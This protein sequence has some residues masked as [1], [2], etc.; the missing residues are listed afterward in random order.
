MIAL[1]KKAASE[2]IADP[3]A[4]LNLIT[5]KF[6]NSKFL[7][8]P[9]GTDCYSSFIAKSI[10][11]YFPS[12]FGFRNISPDF[13]SNY[14]NNAKA[15]SYFTLLEALGTTANSIESIQNFM[16]L[17]N[18]NIHHLKNP[19]GMFL[20]NHDGGFDTPRPYTYQILQNEV[21]NRLAY[22]D[23]ATYAFLFALNTCKRKI[24]V[25][26][27]SQDKKKQILESFETNINKFSSEFYEILF[28]NLMPLLQGK[29]EPK[30]TCDQS[31]INIQLFTEH[32]N[33]GNVAANWNNIRGQITREAKHLI[34]SKNLPIIQ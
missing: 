9:I 21:L 13:A 17:G 16:L 7:I 5:K 32:A 2:I 4:H 24:I 31:Q 22:L 15:M 29:D 33:Y 12:I 8:T 1:S 34:Q 3:I 11:N 27:G 6:Q 10:D 18:G 23:I 26:S 25:F 28:L 14:L 19:F 30:V 20:L